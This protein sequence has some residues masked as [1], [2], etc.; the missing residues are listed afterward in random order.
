MGKWMGRRMGE[1][2]GWREGRKDNKIRVSSTAFNVVNIVGGGGQL[3][4]QS[5]NVY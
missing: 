3:Y 5:L 2:K 4:F 1:W